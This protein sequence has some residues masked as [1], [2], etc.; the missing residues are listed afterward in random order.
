MKNGDLE[1]CTDGS[2]HRIKAPDISGAGWM[3]CSTVPVEDDNP[4]K[5]MK[6]NFW[7]KSNGANSCR[8]NQ[9]E[10]CAIYHMTAALTTKLITAEQKYGV[11]ACSE[12]TCQNRAEDFSLARGSPRSEDSKKPLTNTNNY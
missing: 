1:W 5:V 6:G 11:T 4:M 10:V 2:Y 8:A 9:L 3:C 12:S 7:G